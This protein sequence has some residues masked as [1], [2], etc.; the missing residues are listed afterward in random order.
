MCFKRFIAN[1]VTSS[2]SDHAT[3]KSNEVVE[4]MASR[5]AEPVSDERE[6]SL[7]D[8][9]VVGS[10]KAATDWG[11]H[12]WEY[13]AKNRSTSLSDAASTSDIVPVNTPLLEMSAKD[14]S[15]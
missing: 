9:G 8:T 5:F 15:Y 7:W 14:L 1:H 10:T 6:K 2:Q 3:Q 13:W 4:K 11:I 12:T